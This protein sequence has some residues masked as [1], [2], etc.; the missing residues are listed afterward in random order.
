[1]RAKDLFE[2]STSQ[3][4][5]RT[6]AAAANN[7]KFAK[8][9][10][11]SQ[12]VAREFHAADRKSDYKKLPDHANESQLNELFDADQQYFKLADGQ[13][14]RADFTQAGLN[15]DG[16]SS[17]IKISTVDPKIMPSAA[18]TAVQ[19]WDKARPNI[20][21]AI[22]KWVQGGQ[23]DVSEAAIAEDLRKWFK[24]KWVRFGPDGKIRGDCARGSSS[25]GKPKC[26]PQSKAQSLGKKGRA[27]AAAKKRREDPDPERRGAAKNVATKVK[28]QDITEKWSKKYKSSINCSHPKGFSQKAH[29]AGKK[30]HNE[31]ITMEMTCP[32]CNMCETHGNHSHA[33]LDEA[34]WKGYHKEGNKELFG[35]TVPNCVKNEAVEESHEMCPEC[36]G[37]MY[38]DTMINEKKDACYYKVKS[39]YK[40]WPSAYASGALVKCRKKGAKN[41]GNKNE[42]ANPAQQA[43]IAIAMKK[44]GQK[45]KS[46]GV[47]EGAPELLKKEMPLHRHAEKLLAQNGVSKDDPDYH[48]HLGNTIKHLR[49][50]GNIDLINKSD[51]QGVAEARGKDQDQFG[52]MHQDDF[53][54]KLMRLK[55]LAG[56]GPMKTV[57]DPNKR[58]YKNMP[59]AVQPPR[60]P[61][62]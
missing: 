10:G 2:K 57:Y 21:A 23:Q 36:G 43:A 38:P 8:K 41:W 18:T 54:E 47:A 12:D 1:M 52:G 39:R 56:A 17:S 33:N 55:S 42:A 11:I 29:C 32:D 5:F 25:E 26:L 27:S 3:A 4:Q 40:V 48:H 20:R 37:N 60:Q 19:P 30:K 9:V 44:A 51:E 24:E 34:C 14:I 35:K 46:Q 7:P 16:M 53:Q 31:D 13:V 62:K 59:T 22:Q 28:E 50:F 61:K 15:P 58:V 45:P 6:M 49:Q